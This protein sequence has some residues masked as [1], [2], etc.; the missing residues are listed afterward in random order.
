MSIDRIFLTS[1]ALGLSLFGTSALA[2]ITAAEIWGDWRAYL[3]GMGYSVSAT[4]AAGNGALAVNDITVKGSSETGDAAVILQLGTLRFIENGD[5]SVDVVMPESMPIK[6]D[7]PA[8]GATPPATMEIVYSQTG[9]KMTAR[10]DAAAIAYDYT[11]DA[12]GLALTT[13]TVDGDVLDQNSARFALNGTD[14]TSKTEVT[15]GDSRTYVQNM[16]IGGATYDVF[17]KDPDGLEAV[18]LNS[19]LAALAFSGISV[20][21]T[22][23][24]PQ[25]QDLAPLLESGF[26]FDGTFGVNGT[27]TEVVVTSEEGDTKIKTASARSELAVAMGQNGIRYSTAAKEVQVGG[28]LAGLPFPL[29]IE[30]AEA[31]F[32][33]TAPVLKA[34]TPQDFKFGFNM[35]DFT[36]SDIIWA[37][38]DPAG[39]LPRDPATVVLDLSGKARVLVDG[40]SSGVA[41][42]MAATGAAPAEVEALTI[43]RLT[44]DAIGAKIEATGDLTFDNTDKL[45]LPGFPKPVGD[46]NIDISGANGLMDKLTAMGILPADQAMGARMMMGL[47]AVPGAEPD[48]LKSRIQFDETGQILANGQRIK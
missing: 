27:Q 4:E 20:L 6:I 40:L 28:Q 31:G 12:F 25:T 41:Q 10:G 7:I 22:D 9:H 3:E 2:D 17:F 1:T 26:S 21:P 18:A 29:F 13:L 35:T 39:Q 16:Q 45:T 38:F 23:V 44:A 47:F 30:M 46:I 33:L 36:M 8:E 5:G 24:M 42:Q 14:L 11:A 43:N 48:T 15:T 37:L 32:E 19:T 34:A